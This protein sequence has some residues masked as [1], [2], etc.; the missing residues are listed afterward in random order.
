MHMDPKVD[1]GA[2]RV[3]LA[4][5]SAVLQGL[6]TGEDPE[7]AWAPADGLT[8]LTN[9]NAVATPAATVTYV[10]AATSA[11]G[12]AEQDAV[13]ISVVKD[14]YVPNAFTPNNDGKNDRW[15]IPYLDPVLGAT[16]KV[17]NRYGQLVYQ[18]SGDWVD[19]D[20]RVNG[21]D[22]ATGTYLYLIHFKR[23]RADMKGFLTL[24]K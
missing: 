16:V 22:Q 8:D 10:L 6:V 21:Q 5:D 3:L 14:I 15:H 17:F 20:G 4:G 24:M 9:L 12:C 19:W 7:F 11:F 2:D 13:K 23:G 1:A 18:V